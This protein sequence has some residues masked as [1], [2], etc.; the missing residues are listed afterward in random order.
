MM[1]PNLLNWTYFKFGFSPNPFLRYIGIDLVP[2]PNLSHNKKKIL[3]AVVGGSE[4]RLFDGFPIPYC[5]PELRL[6]QYKADLSSKEKM[7]LAVTSLGFW[8]STALYNCLKAA[9][10]LQ[11]GVNLN[12]SADWR[13]T[14]EWLCLFD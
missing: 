14:S 2:Y 7:N 5:F 1:Q 10:N 12:E 9:Y 11:S 6:K 8:V 13:F 3:A 4:S